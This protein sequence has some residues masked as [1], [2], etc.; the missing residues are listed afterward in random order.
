M[1]SLFC[2]ACKE[3]LAPKAPKSAI[4]GIGYLEAAIKLEQFLSSNP[5]I[6][7]V[8]FTGTAGSYSK[9]LEI[10]NL[11]EVDSVALLNFGTVQRL[12]YVPREY[13]VFT[14]SKLEARGSRLVHCLSSLEITQ[15]EK[16]SGK[17]IEYFNNLDCF[18]KA[19]NDELILI[20]N[21]EL[22]G[23]AKVAEAHKLPWSAQLKITN[24][25]NKN[26]HQDWLKNNQ[27]QA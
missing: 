25:T 26:A 1:T 6:T 17:I 21:M 14:S 8:I 22:Y 16:I 20:E 23:I 11:V 19:R 12:S 27:A 13:E 2:A 9:D 5:D 3:E 7:E 4:L 15:D 24:Y 18:A 10:G